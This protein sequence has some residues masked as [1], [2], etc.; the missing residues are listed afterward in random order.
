MK[1]LW[2]LNEGRSTFSGRATGFSILQGPVVQLSFLRFQGIS[3][4]TRKRSSRKDFI[5]LL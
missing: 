3:L 2:L 1:N 5:D 4:K